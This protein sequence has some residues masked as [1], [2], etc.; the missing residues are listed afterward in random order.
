MLYEYWEHF[1]QLCA[2]CPHHQISDQLLLQYFYKGLLL[3]QVEEYAYKRL[4]KKHEN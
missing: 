3:M 4:Q 1:N 2:S